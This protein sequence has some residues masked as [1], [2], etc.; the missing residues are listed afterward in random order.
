M[1]SFVAQLLTCLL[2]TTMLTHSLN[3]TH[4]HSRSLQPL[5]AHH[6][7]VSRADG[8]ADDISAEDYHPKWIQRS[9]GGGHVQRHLPVCADASSAF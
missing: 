1:H 6:N 8:K 9:S 3:P 2:L 7:S 4:S 5:T